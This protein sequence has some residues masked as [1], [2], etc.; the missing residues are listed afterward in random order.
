MIE[1]EIYSVKDVVTGNFSDIQIMVNRD[2]AIRWFKGLCAES[3]IKND[4]QL[5]YLG[6][7]NL[8]TGE[9][10]SAVD[11]VVGGSDE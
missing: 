11:F 1:Y 9:I 2:C 6:T 8:S 4:L 10:S 5:F 7:Y 3:K